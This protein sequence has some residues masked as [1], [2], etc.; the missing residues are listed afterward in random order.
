MSGYHACDDHGVTTP[1]G[2]LSAL[3][4]ERRARVLRDALEDAARAHAEA[5]LAATAIELPDGAER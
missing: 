4:P 5:T 1:D 2:A 3:E